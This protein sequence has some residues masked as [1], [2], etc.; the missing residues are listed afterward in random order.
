MT[1]SRLRLKAL[2]LSA[3]VLGLMAFG[4]GAARAEVGA[5]WMLNGTDVTA[6][7]T[8]SLD[9]AEIENKTGTFLTKIAG[10]KVEYLCTGA[11]LIGIKLEPSG[12]STG[13][14]GR[15]SGCIARLN[16]VLSPACQ[17]KTAGLPYGE[18]ES[19][20]AKGLSELQGGGEGLIRIE[21]ATAGGNFATIEH[22]GECSLPEKEPVKG[23]LFLK[24]CKNE[25]KVELVTHLI[26]QAPST[27]VFVISDTPEHA[28]NV[29]G[30]ATVKLIGAHEGMKWSGLPG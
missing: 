18:L 13:G 7:L 29:D 27:H 12:K 4:A 24:D 26:E 2:G 8:P 3:V 19:L 15:V 5:S 16:G 1:R 10:A 6:S 30:S 14:K 21:P 22:G 20:S 25:G 23:I 17:P 9:I 11:K 28:V